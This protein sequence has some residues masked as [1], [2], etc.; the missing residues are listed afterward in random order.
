MSE[1]D[2]SGVEL[3]LDAILHRH[4]PGA[5]AEIARKYAE[6][7]YLTFIAGHGLDEMQSVEKT[8]DKDIEHLAKI[9]RDLRRVSKSL[10]KTGL[11]GRSALY[12]YANEIANPENPVYASVDIKGVPSVI[13]G[14]IDEIA[15]RIEDEANRIGPDTLSVSEIL[16]GHKKLGRPI[17]ITAQLVARRCKRV[18][19]DLG[20]APATRRSDW[21][22]GKSYGPFLEFVEEVFK[23]LGIE[24]NAE[25]AIRTNPFLDKIL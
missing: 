24:A 22:T 3:S 9:V 14:K 25:A 8:A 5:D 16:G 6:E 12:D 19:E 11:Q 10:D 2:R 17:H 4:F 1:N 15:D 7:I 18:F 21:R 13:A 23:A 20:D